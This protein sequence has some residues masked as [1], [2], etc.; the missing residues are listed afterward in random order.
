MAKVSPE[1]E[2]CKGCKYFKPIINSIVDGTCRRYPT[3]Q[4][5]CTVDW[6]GEWLKK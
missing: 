3:E 6:C 2:Q 1:P 4:R 5:K